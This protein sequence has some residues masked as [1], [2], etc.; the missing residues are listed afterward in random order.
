MILTFTLY[1]HLHIYEDLHYY[2]TNMN[3]TEYQIIMKTSPFAFF[4]SFSWSSI[5]EEGMKAYC[6]N[7]WT[8]GLCGSTTNGFLLLSFFASLTFVFCAFF[9]II[10]SSP[11]FG[12]S[13]PLSTKRGLL[14]LLLFGLVT[15]LKR[16]LF[17]VSPSLSAKRGLLLLLL[18]GLVTFLKRALFGVSPSLSAIRGH[19]LE[20]WPFWFVTHLRVAL[21]DVSL[22]LSA[23]RGL[24]L[25]K[26]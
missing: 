19:F 15:F 1:E 8:L 21:V 18:F 4:T 10:F 25:R 20:L 2:T 9:A 5:M 23:A 13:L 11:M 24:L 7:A 12:V 22:P 14:L 3:S 17:G 26:L 6:F 16:A